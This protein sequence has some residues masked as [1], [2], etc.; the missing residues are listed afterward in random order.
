MNNF[1]LHP[2]LIIIKSIVNPLDFGPSDI[3]S[4]TELKIN[5]HSK[6]TTGPL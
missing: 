4:K 5:H 1:I 3:N 2:S 6:L